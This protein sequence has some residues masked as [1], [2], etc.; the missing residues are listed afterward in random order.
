MIL[1]TQWYDS[2]GYMRTE[3]S[4]IVYREHIETNDPDAIFLTHMVRRHKCGKKCSWPRP[5][6]IERVLGSDWTMDALLGSRIDP[7][8]SFCPPLTPTIIGGTASGLVPIEPSFRT[9]HKDV[10]YLNGW[11]VRVGGRPGGILH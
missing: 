2:I 9:V 4:V 8:P 1:D 5:E 10:F 3:L 11:T 7:I 6:S